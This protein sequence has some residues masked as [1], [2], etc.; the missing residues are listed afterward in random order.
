M[1]RLTSFSREFEKNVDSE[2]GK[3]LYKALSGGMNIDDI[4]AEHV[5]ARELINSKKTNDSSRN[6]TG[7]T[8]KIQPV[9]NQEH[10]TDLNNEKGGVG[11]SGQGCRSIAGELYR[12]SVEISPESSDNTPL[13]RTSSTLSVDNSVFFHVHVKIQVER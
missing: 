1:E 5:L 2:I 10:F 4:L 7:C 3:D 6:V 8:N 11:S 13:E 9:W 12:G